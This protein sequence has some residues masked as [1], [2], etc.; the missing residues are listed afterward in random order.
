MLGFIER[1]K[2]SIISDI[3]GTKNKNIYKEFQKALGDLV[4]KITKSK[5]EINL[6][7]AH[8]SIRKMLNKPVYY[9]HG[10][11]DNFDHVDRALSIMKSHFNV[12]LTVLELESIVNEVDSMK[13]IGSKYGMSSEG[14]YFL[15]AN[16]R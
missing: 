10:K 7:E 16:F 13:S 11:L 15:K 8:D 9:K 2:T 6:L 4:M 14:V 1:N 3:E 12:D 5:E